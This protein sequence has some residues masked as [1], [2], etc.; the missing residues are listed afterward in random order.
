MANCTVIDEADVELVPQH[1]WTRGSSATARPTKAISEAS[2]R[3]LNDL[4]QIYRVSSLLLIATEMK[5]ISMS[6][7]HDAPRDSPSFH[8]GKQYMDII[9]GMR[10]PNYA[11]MLR[12]TS[13]RHILRAGFCSDH[14]SLGLVQKARELGTICAR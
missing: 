9:R 7:V 4:T 5:L 2:Y 13:N 10:S 14:T 1:P 12:A 6:K 8:T 3:V 11:R